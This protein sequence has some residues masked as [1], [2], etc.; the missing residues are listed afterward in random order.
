MEISS[1]IFHMKRGTRKIATNLPADLMNEAVAL[2]GLNQ[3]ATLI[4]GLKEL[5]AKKKREEL[6]AMKGRLKFPSYSVARTRQRKK[7]V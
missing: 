3:T 1:Y 4:E 7:A 5:I 6:I 2:S